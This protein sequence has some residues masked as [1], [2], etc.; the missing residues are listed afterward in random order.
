MT[1]PIA[2][3]LVVDDPEAAAGWYATVLGAEERSRIPM[4]GG[5]VLTIELAVGETTI[6]LAGEHPDMGIVSPKT[7]GGTYSALV[8]DT[9]DADAL[10]QRALDAGATVFHPLADTFWGK[11]FGQVIDP[12]GHRWGFS[13]HIRD[14]PPDEVARAA[15]EAFGGS[16]GAG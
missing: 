3:H 13:Q 12:F 2:A 5:A 7:L 11:R 1:E 14:V 6:A 10:W 9:D 15:A 8:L 16:T 4:P